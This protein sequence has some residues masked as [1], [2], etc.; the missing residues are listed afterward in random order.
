M[1][2]KPQIG[3]KKTTIKMYRNGN[4]E[5]VRLSVGNVGTT[6]A[7]ISNSFPMRRKCF[8]YPGEIVNVGKILYVFTNLQ[9]IFE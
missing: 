7:S 4:F 2:V 1:Y 5:K 6:S 9:I 8:Q 3:V